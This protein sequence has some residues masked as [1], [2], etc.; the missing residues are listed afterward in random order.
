MFSTIPST[1]TATF[2]NIARPLRASARAMSWGRGHDDR[3][4]HRHALRQRQLDVPGARGHIHHQV[5]Q[6]TPMGV[7]PAAV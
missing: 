4:R 7:A 3:P 1:G 5:I 6:F 2:S